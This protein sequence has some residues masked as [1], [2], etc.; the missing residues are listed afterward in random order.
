MN[1]PEQ[2]KPDGEYDS[3]VDKYD[4]VEKIETTEDD[5]GDFTTNIDYTIKQASQWTFCR[6][7]PE[8]YEA[9]DWSDDGTTRKQESDK[10]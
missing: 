4:C 10:S 1:D 8:R 3:K 7:D 2:D 6:W 5:N 9:I